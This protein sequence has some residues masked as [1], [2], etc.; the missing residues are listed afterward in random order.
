MWKRKNKIYLKRLKAI[1][2]NANW[3]L[4]RFLRQ[5][6]LESYFPH[7]HTCFVH[8]SGKMFHLALWISEIGQSKNTGANMEVHR[9]RQIMHGYLTVVFDADN[10]VVEVSHQQR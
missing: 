1:K 5:K 7:K 3:F 9:L 6:L 4:S 10:P 2:G 8:F